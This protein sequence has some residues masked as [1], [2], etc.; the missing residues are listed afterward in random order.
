MDT[1]ALIQALVRALLRPLLGV[2]LLLLQTL[3]GP[4]RSVAAYPASYLTTALHASAR[5]QATPA[6]RVE[7]LDVM[8]GDIK[9]AGTLTMPD[10][11]DGPVPAVVL[12]TGSGAQ[13]RDEDIFGFKIFG[14]LADQL[15][16]QGIAVYR[17]DDRGVGGSTGSIAT[18]TTEDFA[19]DALAA[20]GR[21]QQVPGVDPKRVGL[22]GH[23]EGAGAAAIAAAKSTD[24][25][26][27]VMLAGTGVP[28]DQVL[29]QQA[30]DIASVRGATPAQVDRIVA[31]H[32]AATDAILRDA[33]ADERL[34]L[35]RA[36]VEAQVDAAPRAQLAAIKNVELYIEQT[37]R[38]AA[39]QMALPWMKYM[40]T[41]DPAAPLRELRVPVYA[42]FGSL[43]MQ[44]PP[45]LN[46]A[47]VRQ[48][49]AGNA[50]A[51]IKVYP[52]ANHLFQRAK[53][54]QVDEYPVLEKAFVSGLVD[55][56]GRWI[57]R[58]GR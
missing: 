8:H 56:V 24:V 46:E 42:A 44:V 32:K 52:D 48:A 12:I 43:D 14:I 11:T 3:M 39:M 34:R 1:R 6:Y 16:R 38:A 21:L 47:P 35:V 15:T 30:R 27:I 37:S 55:D 28:G 18:A 7:S 4:G 2:V 10:T 5:Q 36:L 9:L 26:F 49:L 13:N 25:A 51:A 33:P 54:G 40:L 22:V 31:A 50:R 45:S 58:V 23:S 53:S 41:F 29:R 20:L 17:Y 19:G 57:L